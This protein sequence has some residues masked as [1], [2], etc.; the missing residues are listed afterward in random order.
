M[1]EKIRAYMMRV[2]E[3]GEVYKGYF[4][5]IENTLKVMQGFVGGHI[6]VVSLPS[7]IVLVC[8]EEGKLMKL[9]PNRALF[10]EAGGKDTVYDFIAGNCLC[11]RHNEEGD[12]TPILDEDISIIQRFAKPIRLI[13][14]PSLILL[15]DED[16]CEDWREDKFVDWGRYMNEP[17]E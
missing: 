16:E 4:G 17:I 11:V 9:M 1:A 12:F 14:S 2:S 3:D 10:R 7:G 15:K 8:G 6:Q 13:A 5:E